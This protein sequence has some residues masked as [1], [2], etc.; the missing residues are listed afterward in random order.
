MGGQHCVD[1]V[2]GRSRERR[3]DGERRRRPPPAPRCRN[4]MPK[5]AIAAP[6]PSCG[7][8]D[9]E[10]GSEAGAAPEQD[11]RPDARRADGDGEHAPRPGSRAP[12]PEQH[13]AHAHERADRRRERDR[14]VGVDDPGREA[15]DQ[16]GDGERAAPEQQRR[17]RAVG[18]PARHGEGEPRDE[19]DQRRGKQPRDLAAE[20][21]VEQAGRARSVPTSSRWRRWRRRCRTRCRSACRS[22]CSRRSG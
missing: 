20:A 13:A 7:D 10:P 21:G 17:A 3:G 18:A 6:I 1:G 12:V 15:E 16:R 19:Q 5:I 8:C 11:G 22:R 14:V 4:G 9:R 2:C